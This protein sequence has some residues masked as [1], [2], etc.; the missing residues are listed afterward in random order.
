MQIGFGDLIVDPHKERNNKKEILTGLVIST[1]FTLIMLVL[2]QFHIIQV[3]DL[4]P[5][6]LARQLKSFLHLGQN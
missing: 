3:P 1:I 2:V 6:H 5:E 4:Q